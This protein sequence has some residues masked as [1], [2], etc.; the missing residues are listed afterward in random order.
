VG[1]VEHLHH[2][3][4]E[5]ETGAA[6]TAGDPAGGSLDALL[7]PAEL[8]LD[9][10]LG[11]EV[12]PDVMVKGMVADLVPGRRDHG[13]ELRVLCQRGVLTDDEHRDGQIQGL[14]EPQEAGH[15]DGEV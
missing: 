14:Q 12:E 5:T 9:L 2:R 13:H 7:G 15:H 1:R 8:G 6:K 10:R 3:P 11:V 4:G